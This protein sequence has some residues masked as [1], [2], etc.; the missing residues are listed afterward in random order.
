MDLEVLKERTKQLH[1]F[2]QA[3]FYVAPAAM[4]K[5]EIDS[6]ELLLRDGGDENRFPVAMFK[7]FVMSDAANQ[8]YWDGIQENLFMI[9]SKNPTDRFAINIDP[10]QLYFEST[11]TFFEKIVEYKDQLLI[12]ITETVPWSRPQ[13]DYYNPS[14]KK[15]IKRFYDMGYKV[16]MDDVSSGMNSLNMV[17]ECAAYI[18]RIKLSLIQLDFSDQKVVQQV[19]I[20]WGLVAQYLKVEIVIE[21]IDTVIT[22]IWVS[23]NILGLQQGFYLSTPNEVDNI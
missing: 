17:K 11:Y 21:G 3:I 20:M 10:Q 4:M 7:Q 5:R 19:I 2:K 15:H 16:A 8:I 18:T 23:N 12:E 14:L 22:N 6:Y 1:F 13:E 9:L